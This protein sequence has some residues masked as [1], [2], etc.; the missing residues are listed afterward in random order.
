[1]A[2]SAR[3]EQVYTVVLV[4]GKGKRLRPLSTALRPKAFLSFTKDYKTIFRR[5]L[6]RVRGLVPEKNVI[7]VANRIH[8]GLARKDFPEIRSENLI[9]EPVSRNTAPA[10]ALAASK[11][12]QNDPDA[13]MAV[14]PT[15][16]YITE[17]EKFLSPVRQGIKFIKKNPEAIV[18]MGVKPRYPSTH[19]GYIKVENARISKVQKFV[20]KPDRKTAEKYV[21]EGNY[22]W[23]TGAF[24]FKVDL[25]LKLIGKF[26]P[27]IY[28]NVVCPEATASDYR[29]A[30][31]LSID[32]AVIEKYRNIYCV[33]A[34]YEWHDLGGFESLIK[35]LTL[36]GRKFELKGGKV[37]KI[38]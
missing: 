4:G 31:D 6:D 15:D 13:I 38:K 14:L 25:L 21:K 10:I 35:I 19:F 12:A 20:E 29:K 3:Q 34:E 27:K 5:T 28:K 2:N 1:M 18:I 36:E 22:L 32:Y 17:E 23:N 26:A 7:V 24:I 37:V 9:L 30:P 16:Q 8:A 11:L 33:K